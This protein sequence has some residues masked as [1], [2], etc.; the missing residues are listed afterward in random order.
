M[1]R[2]DGTGILL[3]ELAEWEKVGP[4][5]DERLKGISFANDMLARRLALA[6]RSRV[7]IRE[8]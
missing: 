4:A 5:E 1:P 6:L 8:G 2:P 3:V 7:D